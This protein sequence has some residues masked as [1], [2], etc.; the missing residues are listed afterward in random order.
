MEAEGFDVYE[1][2]WWHFDF[3]GWEKYRILTDTFEALD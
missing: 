2:E 3:H 1:Y